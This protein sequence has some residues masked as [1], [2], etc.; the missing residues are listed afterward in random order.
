MQVNNVNNAYFLNVSLMFYVTRTR[1]WSVGHDTYPSVGHEKSE[2]WGHGDTVLFLDTGTGTH[3]SVLIN[4][5][6]K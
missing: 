4:K 2:N 1:V 6:G 5:Y 3:C